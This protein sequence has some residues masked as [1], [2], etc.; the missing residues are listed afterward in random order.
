MT[1]LPKMMPN[2][3]QMTGK[4]ALLNLKQIKSAVKITPNE[5]VE[6]FEKA[7]DLDGR[8]VLKGEKTKGKVFK[9]IA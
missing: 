9:L 1:L 4:C 8:K 2:D 3:R 5:E 7:A 6:T